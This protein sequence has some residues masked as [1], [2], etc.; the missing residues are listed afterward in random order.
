MPLKRVLRTEVTEAFIEGLRNCSSKATSTY[1][2]DKLDVAAQM[3]EKLDEMEGRL[4]EQVQKN[5]ELHEV[6][7]TY[8]KNEILNELAR[9]LDSEVQKDKFTSLAEA[10][11]FKTEESYREKLGQIKESYFGIRR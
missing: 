4:N 10:V 3:S 6:V 9:G 1:L 8:R 11:E 7:G 5:I 2:K